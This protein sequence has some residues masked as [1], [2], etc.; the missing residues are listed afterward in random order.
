MLLAIDIGNSNV[1]I[2]VHHHQ[3]WTS[4]WRLPTHMSEN[5]VAFYQDRISNLFLE[6][7][8]LHQPVRQ[9][10]ISSVVPS[11]TV[12]I[13]DLVA[14]L[15][16]QDP[17]LL[18]PELYE[19]LHL[20]VERKEQLGTDLYA[21]AMAAHHLY[22]KDCIIVDFGTALTFTIVDQSGALLGVNIA[23]G[24]KTA[25]HA[26]F[27]N[28]AQLPEVPLV[29]P[30]SAVGKNTT[31]A[32]QSGILIGYVGLVKYMLAEIRKELGD[33]FVAIGT[34]GLVHILSPL[35]ESFHAINPNLTLEGLRIIG[36]KV[37]EQVK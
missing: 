18:G 2:G 23:P 32:I 10:V 7:G 24:L 11:L 15:F 20:K 27:L 4:T 29:Y 3:K 33:S 25:I 1:V 35:Q 8:L 14:Q 19:H 37:A 5:P 12:V 30:E 31:H 6:Q 22:Q 9:I 36:E 13:K 21:N 28:T 26:L 34:G 16:A 17:I